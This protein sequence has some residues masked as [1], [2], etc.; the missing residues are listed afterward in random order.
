MKV[1]GVVAIFVVLFMI[2]KGS[3]REVAVGGNFNPVVVDFAEGISVDGTTVI[4][5][6]GGITTPTLTT[7]G[8]TALGSATAGV[9]QFAATLA[10]TTDT[11]LT[12]SQSGSTIAMGTAGL[13]VTLPAVASSNGVWFRF[14][15]SAAYT[16]TNMTVV[17]AEG[18]NIEGQLIVAGAVVDCTANDVITSVNDGE[19]IGDFFLLYSN[20]TNWFI[21][22]SGGLTA[23]KLTC[24]G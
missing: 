3:Q 5:G 15:V 23:S 2:G 20:G 12:A 19:D 7:T 21:G 13:D 17:S 4:S 11:T 16:T 9:N 10:P 22:P 14:V 1:V 18:D 24:T 6:S 8:A